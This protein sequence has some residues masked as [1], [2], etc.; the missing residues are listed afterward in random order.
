[1]SLKEFSE[2]DQKFIAACSKVGLPKSFPLKHGGKTF[3]ISHANLGLRRQASKWLRQ[4]GIAYK[5]G[6]E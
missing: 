4:E 5:K 3:T 6:R 1:M 2:T